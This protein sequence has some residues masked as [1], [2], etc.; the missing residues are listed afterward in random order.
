MNLFVR[1][2][3][4]HWAIE[5]RVEV[6]SKEW[7]GIRFRCSQKK[8]NIAFLMPY[9][10]GVAPSQRFRFEQYI[11]FL[12][13]QGYETIF[14]PFINKNFNSFLYSKDFFFKKALHLMF[15]FF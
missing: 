13:Q 15:S 5:S 10:L 8:Y 1:K 2:K 14:F 12:N 9:P 3:Y 7:Y 11:P 6:F 4:Y